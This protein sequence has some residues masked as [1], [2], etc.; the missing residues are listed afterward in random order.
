MVWLF[1]LAASFLMPI[2]SI[3]FAVLSSVCLLGY[4]TTTATVAF[5]RR[6]FMPSPA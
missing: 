3:A 2:L 5:G 4:L 1:V 6:A